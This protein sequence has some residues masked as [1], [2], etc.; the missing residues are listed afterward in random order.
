MTAL[1]ENRTKRAFRLLSLD[2]GGIRGLSELIIIEEIMHRIQGREKLHK[3]PLPADYFDLIGGTSMSGIIAILLGRLRLSAAQAIKAYE[4]FAGRSSRRRKQK[5]KM[6]H[7]RRL[8]LR[9]QSRAWY[10]TVSRT[11]MLGSADSGKAAEEMELKYKNIPGIYYRLDVNRG[12]HSIS[13]D[14]WKSLGKVREHTKN[15]M[16][17]EAIDKRVDAIV[18]RLVGSTLGQTCKAGQLAGSVTPIIHA[19][20]HSND[21]IQAADLGKEKTIFMVPFGQDSQFVGRENIIS[22]IDKILKTEQ[23]VGL[24]GKGG[25]GKSQI[26]IEYN[27]RYRSK[28]PN[29]SIFWVPSRAFERFEK[30]YKDIGR[31]LNLPGCN[32]PTANMLQ[33]VAD[34]LTDEDHS[35][36][37]MVLDNVD[38]ADIFFS[39]GTSMNQYAPPLCRYLP[40]SAKGSILITSRDREAVFRLINRIEHVIDV[41]PMEEEDARTL[42]PYVRENEEV[43]LAGM[44]DL[45]RDPSVPNSILLTWRIAFD[46]I[47][48]SNPPAADLL[49]LMSVIDRQ[50][51]PEFL[52]CKD[53]NRLALEDALAPLFN[54]ALIATDADSEGFEMYRLVQLATRTWLH[55]HGE[56]TKWEEEAVT[57]LSKSFP[58]SRHENWKVCGALLPHAEAVLGY[59]FPE[60]HYSLL[61][62]GVLTVQRSIYG[63]KGSMVWLYIEAIK[64]SSLALTAMVLKSQ[65]KYKEAEAM[66]R[67]WLV[68]EETVQGPEHPD[69]LTSIST[70]P[71]ALWNQGKHEEAEA[72]H[73]RA[74]ALRK[75]VLG[76]DYP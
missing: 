34:W 74:L 35:H 19:S 18:D 75:T 38:D 47:K 5:G 23:R 24:T 60:Q 62:A 21:A 61:Q 55:I 70:L 26:A 11:Q 48:K 9:M 32:D 3:V 68:L 27:Y 43:L 42:L 40:Q 49:S 63:A 57:L 65:G 67:R 36:W 1:P 59:Q 22:D 13:L 14:E 51:N 72:M 4:T 31:R 28:H 44:G 16:R 20:I 30:A 7:S 54:F 66:S 10:R 33:I 58:N 64:L 12:L 2:G 56:L 69:T 76:P 25:V 46:Q 71:S 52:L 15:Y 73:R 17:T 39:E 8:N 50:G 37:L 45:R 6:E 41:L 29:H 53:D